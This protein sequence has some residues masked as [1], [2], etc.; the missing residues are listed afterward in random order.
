MIVPTQLSL[1]KLPPRS[2]SSLEAI[3]PHSSVKWTVLG[4]FEPDSITAITKKQNKN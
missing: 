1:D 4:H 3:E 2:G